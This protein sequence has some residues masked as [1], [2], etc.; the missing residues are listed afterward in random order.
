MRWLS[1][2][3]FPL[4][5]PL[6][7]AAQA[8]AYLDSLWNVYRT[9]DQTREDKL[10][11]FHE[12]V[13]E[14]R[15]E[16]TDSA[17]TLADEFMRQA[18]ASGTANIIAL[19]HRDQGSIAE[20]GR[21]NARAL[22]EY[23]KAISIYSTVN[24]SAAVRGMAA[25]LHN[26]GL[27]HKNMGE[28]DSA[29]AL[30]HR[31]MALDRRIGN[32]N[33]LMYCFGSIGRLYE[34][35]GNNDSALA[36]YERSGGIAQALGEKRMVAAGFGNRA[37]VYE[38]MGALGPAIDY[39]YRCLGIMEELGNDRGIATSLTTVAS[40]RSTLGQ[41]KEALALLRRSHALYD[42][43]GYRQGVMTSGKRI[44][45]V[46]LALGRPDSAM[47]MLEKAVALEREFE[48]KDLMSETLN[49]L[50]RAYRLTGRT[51]D[52]RR[53]LTESLTI[54]RELKDGTSE[55]AALALLGRVLLDEGKPADAIRRCTEGL[56]LA[57][58]VK[59]LAERGENCECLYLA[60]KAKG[61]GMSAVR[62]LEQY[63][64][65][66]D[67]IASEKSSRELTQRDLL[68]TF[69]KQ[70]MADSLRYAEAAVRTSLQA[71]MR[72]VQTRSRYLIAGAA[73]LLVVIGLITYFILDRRRR[74]AR[75]EKDAAQLET[76]ALRSQMNPHFIFNALNSINAFVQQND[77]DRASAYLSKFARLM[78][79]VLENSRQAEVPLKD[80][81]EALDLYLNLERARSR[82]AN[83][84][85]KFDYK[86]TVDPDIDQEETYV[87][88]LVIQPFV[89]NA[90]W[91]GMAGKQEKGHIALSVTR[92][93]EELILAIED[94][95][96][97]RGAKRVPEEV[98]DS[99][100]VRRAASDEVPDS[101]GVRR[102]ASDEVTDSAGVRRA[103]S[104]EVTDS[105]VPGAARRRASGT[106]MKKTSLAT[107]I[108]K[109][110]LDLVQKQKGKPAGFRII[111]LEQGT[112]VE[113]SL[114]AGEA[115]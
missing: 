71:E 96:V 38:R 57:E 43:V 90:I 39:A 35:Q 52:A 73:I 108:T 61:D 89:E 18:L 112:R 6:S 85:A 62:Y 65:V 53:V 80:D 15:Y 102:A 9:A 99:A 63:E 31:S 98:P 109:A 91:H 87:P 33:G 12:I 8:N 46:M 94:D 55:C 4:L 70:Q 83:G 107:T 10:L 23:R 78:R 40:L 86:I 93:G 50:A 54:A 110:R 20:A 58:Q 111:D 72:V 27:I 37:N 17:Q 48:A 44:G 22:Q 82:D 114:P 66:Q 21:D 92:S 51:T 11:T 2:L 100:G 104:D 29:L 25:S 45:M 69:S 59:V 101:A 68:Y 75:F 67:S 7:C 79:L 32:Q 74:Q 3:L 81:L 113:V 76:Q 19:A 13:D 34:I 41:E 56:R 97:G 47:V 105:A 60:Y 26:M 5:V 30:Y 115:V 84:G 95:G 42:K 28:L 16:D 36:N 24:D 103:A 49:G 106:E 14:T 64:D 77:S 1:S 88:P